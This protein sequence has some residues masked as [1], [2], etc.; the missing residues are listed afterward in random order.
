MPNLNNSSQNKFYM[1]VF[2]KICYAKESFSQSKKSKF[3]CFYCVR[4]S[5]A[6]FFKVKNSKN[7][8]PP[9][10]ES[11]ADGTGKPFTSCLPAG[12]IMKKRLWKSF[13]YC[14]LRATTMKNGLL[15]GRFFMI[16]PTG[17]FDS[18]NEKVKFKPLHCKADMIYNK[19]YFKVHGKR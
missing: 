9:K 17:L 1:H 2:F 4:P 8:M 7:Y 16:L 13:Y 3:N 14:N 10:I 11:R 12:K 5:H 6:R 15:H 19:A 18:L